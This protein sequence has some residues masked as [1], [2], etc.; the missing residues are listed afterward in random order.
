MFRFHMLLEQVVLV[1]A[2]SCQACK[3]NKNGS[4]F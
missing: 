2:S 3:A 1:I 4:N